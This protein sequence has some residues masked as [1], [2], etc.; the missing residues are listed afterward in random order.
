[1]MADS[2]ESLGLNGN[3]WVT[4]EG[5]GGGGLSG[6]KVCPGHRWPWQP[7]SETNRP[8]ELRAEYCTSI[9]QAV[10]KAAGWGIY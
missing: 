2:R 3:G 7:G 1:M 5:R 4:L 10:V 6:R 9:C 8:A